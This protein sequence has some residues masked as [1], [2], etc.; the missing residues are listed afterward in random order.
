MLAPIVVDSSQALP[1]RFEGKL[2]SDERARPASCQEVNT[3]N[4][5]SDAKSRDLNL[6][7]DLEPDLCRALRR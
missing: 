3:R 5:K 7:G 6:P 1:N 4:F 2:S